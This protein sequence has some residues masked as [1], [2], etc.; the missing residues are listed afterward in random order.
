[1]H[2]LSLIETLLMDRIWDS[3]EDLI[4]RN[5]ISRIIKISFNDTD[6]I[7]FSYYIRIGLYCANSI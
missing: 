3:K 5:K 2:V 4:Q 1:M 6:S 7:A